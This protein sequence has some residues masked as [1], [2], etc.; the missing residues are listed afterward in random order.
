MIPWFTRNYEK[1]VGRAS[2]PA[3]AII[4]L[5]FNPFRPFAFY[6]ASTISPTRS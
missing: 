3:V 2:V 4:S 6:P 1:S 5:A